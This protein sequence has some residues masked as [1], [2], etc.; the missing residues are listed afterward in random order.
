MRSPGSRRLAY[1]R[2]PLAAPSGREPPPASS[3]RAAATAPDGEACARSW[4]RELRRSPSGWPPGPARTARLQP[5]GDLVARPGQ[6]AVALGPHFQHCRVVLSGHL[7]PGPGSQRRR[8]PSTGR[9]W[10]RSCSYPLQQPHPGRQLGLYI[11]DALASGN[12]LLGEQVTQP[13]GTLDHPGPPR[14]GRRPLEQLPGLCSRGPDPRHE[15][16]S[17][18]SG[19]CGAG[20]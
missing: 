10:G 14:P 2:A 16:S 11:Q 13:A 1:L 8:R 17:R 5:A 6:V 4:Q 3:A 20:R 12:E 19:R 18:R 7:P 15:G 9:R